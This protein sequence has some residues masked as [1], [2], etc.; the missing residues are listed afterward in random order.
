MLFK[1]WMALG[2]IS[3]ALLGSFSIWGNFEREHK[4][5]MQEDRKAAQKLMQD[6]N[7][8]ESLD[9]YLKLSRNPN[10]NDK[11]LAEDWGYIV[12][13]LNNLSQIQQF[14]GL[15]EEFFELH[16]TKPHFL[17][18]LATSFQSIGNYGYVTAGNFQRGDARGSGQ[19]VNCT[20][21]DRVRA[22]QILRN[23][24]AVV[25]AADDLALQVAYFSRL[26]DFV[27]WNIRYGESWRFQELTDLGA[28]P[29]FEEGGWGWRG[30]WGGGWGGE[31]RGAPVDVDGNPV[32]YAIPESW[33]AAK[34]DGERWRFALEAAAKLSPQ[35]RLEADWTFASFM[36]EQFGVQTMAQWGTFFA[37]RVEAESDDGRPQKDSP[38]A[39][40]TLTDEETI[41]KLATGVKRF[42]LP[43][44]F[45]PVLLFQKIAA[46]SGTYQTNALEQLA[47][48]Y[49]DRQQY[50]R[51]AEF[52]RKLIELT[53]SDGYRD[54]LAQVVDPWGRFET[55]GVQPA[56][57]GAK[58]EYRFRNGKEVQ[59]S[60]RKVDMDRLLK[61]TIDYLK[62]KPRELDWQ[63]LQFSSVAHSILQKDMQK[64]VGA[65]VA[66]WN[67]PLEPRP[68]HFDRRIT[69]TTP[70]QNAGAYLV[71]AKM[72]NGNESHIVVFVE[73]T[74]IF[75]K[76]IDGKWLY[77]V[78]DAVT[79]QPIANANVEFFGWKHVWDNRGRNHQI[80]IGNFAEKTDREGFVEAN[81]KLMVND[82]SWIAV[83]RSGGRMA[84]LG[85]S[86]GWVGNY[87]SERLSGIKTYGI[88][89]RPIYR[90]NQDVKFKFW[91]RDTS[92]APVDKQPFAGQSVIVK[93]LDPQG[94]ELTTVNKTA[95]EFGGVDGEYRLADGAALGTYR[96]LIMDSENRRRGLYS[97]IRFQVE[98]YKKPEFEVTVTPPE[99]PVRLG[100]KVPV[101]IEANYFFGGAVQEGTV[102]YKVH[103][104]KK[105]Q[106]W[107]PIRPWDW[108]YGN[109]YWWFTADY[110]WYPGFKTWGC[111]A[112]MP[113]W[114][115]HNPDPP[116]L[117]LDIETK[118]GPDGTVEFEIDTALAKEI[119]GDSDHEYQITA[120]VV[121]ASRRTIVGSGSVIVTRR[122]F[123]VYI[124]PSRGYSRVGD[125]IELEMM[126]RTADGKGVAGSGKL[127]L[128]KITY[129]ADGTPTETPMQSWDVDTDESGSARQTIKATEPGQFRVAYSVTSAEGDSVEG[130]YVINVIGDGFDS[131]NFR[132]NDLEILT[133]KAEYAP[134]DKVKLLINTNRADSFV[135]LWLRPASIYK[136]RPVVLRLNGK[137]TT[138]EFEVNQDD[139]PNFFVEATTLS[140]AKLHEVVKEVIVPPAK[141][142]VNVEVLPTAT[143]VL[144]GEETKVELRLTDI[145]GRPFQ[146]SLVMTMYD[147]AVEHI[148]GGSNVPD[149]QAHFWKWKRSHNPSTEHSLSRFAGNLVREGQNW[150]NNLGIFG[151]ISADAGLDGDIAGEPEMLAMPSMSMDDGAPAG[152]EMSQEAGKPQAMRKNA[153]TFGLAGGG[154]AD[155]N[156]AGGEQVEQGL[157]APTVR[158]EFADAAFWSVSLK[159]NSD[160][161]AE[162]TIKMPE[163]LTAWKVRTWALG[164][165]TEVGEGTAEIKTAKNIM[166]RLQAPRFFVEKDEVVLSAV[167]HNYLEENK[168]TRV[169][170][171][172]GG[173]EL[174]TSAS[175]EVTVDIPAG[176]E[177]RVDWRVRVVR[178]GTAKI[179]MAALTDV[180]SDA[181]EMSFPVFVHGMLKTESYSGIVRDGTESISFDI[182][183]PAERRPD[184]SHLEVR[185]SPTLA[186]AM[187]DALPYL[188][189]Y[190]YGC[191]EQTLNRFIPTVITHDILKRMNL[192]LAAIRDKQVNLNPQEI[193]DARDRAQRWQ[194]VTRRNPVFDPAEVELM[195]KQGVKDLTAMQNSDGGW[196]W[197]SGHIERS[198]PHTTSVVVHGLQLAQQRGIALVPGMLE[199][200]LEWLKNY[201][202]EQLR[203]LAEWDRLEK[204]DREKWPKNPHYKVSADN[205]DAFIY[206]I[207]LEAD[208]LDQKMGDYLFRDRLK[209]SL[210]GQALAGLA[211]DK[212]QAVERR[213]QVI[214]NIDQFMKYDEENQSAFIDLP[215]QTYWWFWYGNSI[216]ANAFYLKLLSRVNPQD[217]KAAGLVKYL[218]NN[219]RHATYWSSTRDTA[220]CIEALAEF[221]ERS[222]ETDPNMTVEILIDGVVK[223][224]V[225]IT[226][227]VLFQFNNAFVLS[228]SELTDGKHTVEIR[229]QGKG[230]VYANAYLTNFTLEDDIAAAGLEIKVERQFYRLEQIKDAKENVAGS[231]GQVVGQAVEKYKRVPLKNWDEVKSGD[232]IEIELEIDSKNDYEYVV[233]EDMKV[234]GTEPVDLRSGYLTGAFR[235]YVEFRDERV[236][237]FTR[238]LGQGKHSVSY[239][240]RAEIPGRFSALPTKAWAMYAPE[241]RANSSEMK[242]TIE[243]S[244]RTAR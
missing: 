208:F 74:A 232:L 173:D 99:K 210:Y 2:T 123:A 236:A 22:L 155:F 15:V 177:T 86:G 101:K 128:F 89:D 209:L 228:G 142:V 159:P 118:I 144:P 33:D 107:Y 21:R 8:R 143:S 83:A 140:G 196:G 191:T 238:Q 183:V 167:V 188:V 61:D 104:T 180:E 152:R 10:S 197:F 224:A 135:L 84:Y 29:D 44:D 51:A 106:R 70:L 110:D 65:E 231:R 34:N 122:P 225:E 17:L 124:W 68:N 192:D 36:H 25:M 134:G 207:L 26:A 156:M 203:L 113:W 216:E 109:G 69:I 164:P 114:W 186:G 120:E 96:L 71:Q 239:R 194:Q 13:N 31:S 72:A 9:L 73:D 146:G 14:D 244:D 76:S 220:Y 35:K 94:T 227:Q 41:A 204:L 176:G 90:P 214:R 54:L 242:L 132:Y 7:Y 5:V 201:Q 53:N 222:G 4:H 23:A 79:G 241:L 174:E 20:R 100:D 148:S 215:N 103:R 179:T 171:D 193:G 178:E 32:L 136:A 47:N 66:N 16:A 93:L 153:A 182:N 130:G 213:D 181:M 111:L 87:G 226:P 243:E 126:A 50:P 233:F 119:H 166:V 82:M 58:L 223:Q 121:D 199:R 75:R 117:V 219:R 141:K 187:V 85:F 240:V 57:T 95:D 175:R 172:L 200:G 91:I 98:E 97:E 237:F 218:L 184:Q 195:T 45:N 230:N 37:P 12:Q 64:Y 127:S 43:A 112:P 88:T 24:E 145:D 59:L 48:L 154:R 62:T 169:T 78:G 161:I 52:W 46:N 28:L 125:A 190:P 18:S 202:A 133:D 150:M 27:S 229:R 131:A 3:V 116:E 55:V 19:W 80:E 38:Y 60:A 139:M 40:S 234:A 102:S 157:A 56:G 1:T 115:G 147:R 160:G 185:F 151:N 11:E 137:S 108:L 170:L 30:R 162:A 165:Q 49:Q 42:K 221:M 212:Q 67:V 163:N 206:M 6:G 81:P 189:D 77:F 205:L 211:F 39:V 63:R 129:A 198:F 217:P 235:A 105:D 168:T 158:R 138:Y 92:Y 149:I